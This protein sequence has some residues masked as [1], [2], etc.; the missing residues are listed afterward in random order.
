MAVYTYPMR[1]FPVIGVAIVAIAIGAG[2]YYL[3]PQLKGVA[4]APQGEAAPIAQATPVSFRVLDS[5]THASGVTAATNYAAYSESSYLKLWGM[6][7]GTDQSTPPNVDFSKEYVIGVFA[8]QKP[9]GGYAVA[10]DTVSDENGTR[11]V[12]IALTKPGPACITNQMVTSPY[13]LIAVPVS[14]AALAHTESDI[15]TPCK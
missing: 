6:V 1:A 9:T 7:H 2:I 8:G 10:I 14:D 11:T 3:Q 15:A 13:Q 4:Y 12:H 5:G